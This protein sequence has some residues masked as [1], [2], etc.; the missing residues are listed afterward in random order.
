MHTIRQCRL[1]LVICSWNKVLVFFVLKREQD[2]EM[3]APCLKSVLDSSSFLY[4]HLKWL[5]MNK[6]HK[7]LIY[8]CKFLLYKKAT[9][10][11]LENL[12]NLAASH[13]PSINYFHRKAH[14]II[15][16][17]QFLHSAF[18]LCLTS[19]GSTKEN[20]EK[21]LNWS[22]VIRMTSF[23]W[24]CSEMEYEFK[25]TGRG[26]K[27]KECNYPLEMKAHDLW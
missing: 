19:H 20:S 1:Y 7:M 22:E 21:T 5:Q 9:N 25:E 14:P 12:S 17:S 16:F 4:S 26:K 6:M 11:L 8:R 23:Y 24:C 10:H 2:T 13:L 3:K 15:Y 27:R 18:L